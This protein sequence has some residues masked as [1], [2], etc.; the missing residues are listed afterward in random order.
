MNSLW[1]GLE[2]YEGTIIDMKGKYHK[3][4]VQRCTLRT[5]SGDL[6]GQK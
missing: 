3:E 1:F 2:G 5:L 6:K 4:D